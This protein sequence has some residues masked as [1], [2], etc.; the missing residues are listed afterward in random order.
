MDEEKVKIICKQCGVEFIDFPTYITMVGEVD[1]NTVCDKCAFE[2]AFG[3]DNKINEI[4]EDLEKN[5]ST[6]KN[7]DNNSISEVGSKIK[8]K[9]TQVGGVEYG[10]VK[11]REKGKL[12]GGKQFYKK[13]EQGPVPITGKEYRKA[14]REARKERRQKRKANK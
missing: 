14:K 2:N 9:R 4:K 5:I 6:L 10:K 7:K 13:G 1:Q 8:E 12:F 3:D 11:A